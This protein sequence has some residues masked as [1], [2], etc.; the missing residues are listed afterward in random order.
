VIR[1]RFSSLLLVVSKASSVS[2]KIWRTLASRPDLSNSLAVSANF[3]SINLVKP[4][5]GLSARIRASMMAL[6]WNEGFVQ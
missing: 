4:G 2:I 1:T 5:P 3:L 6:Y